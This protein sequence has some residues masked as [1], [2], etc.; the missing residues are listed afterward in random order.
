MKIE[1]LNEDFTAALVTL[2]WFKKRYAGFNR[3]DRDGMWRYSGTDVEVGWGP[4]GKRIRRALKRGRL[5]RLRAQIA[6]KY[7]TKDEA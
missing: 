5:K 6:A 7:W 4:S 1:W 3:S 2:G